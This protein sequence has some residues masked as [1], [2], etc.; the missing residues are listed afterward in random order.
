MLGTLCGLGKCY[1]CYVDMQVHLWLTCWWLP[2]VP[3]P[4]GPWPCLCCGGGPALSPPQSS[5]ATL[6]PHPAD[7]V[8]QTVMVCLLS[9]NHNIVIK[10][11][12]ENT[13]KCSVSFNDLPQVWTTL[14]V[15]SSNSWCTNGMMWLVAGHLLSSR[16]HGMQETM[17]GNAQMKK[18]LQWV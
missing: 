9:A 17:N 12:P 14:S 16:I 13:Q 1:P 5:L 7:A 11:L 15:L 10:I 3:D 4:A 18:Y 2:Q 6:P 8:A